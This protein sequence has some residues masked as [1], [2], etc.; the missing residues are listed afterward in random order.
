[1]LQYPTTIHTPPSVNRRIASRVVLFTLALFILLVILREWRA[2]VV[3]LVFFFLGDMFRFNLMMGMRVDPKPSLDVLKSISEHASKSGLLSRM[4]TEY[5]EMV[6]NARETLSVKIQAGV[7]PESVA[8]SP[9]FLQLKLEQF[10]TFLNL[11]QEING[12]DEK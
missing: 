12:D 8:D 4:S 6:N 10:E 2:A 11:V 9:L 7:Y 1:M 5:R 3:A